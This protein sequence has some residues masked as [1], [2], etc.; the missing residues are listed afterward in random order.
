MKK[1]L[2]EMDKFSLLAAVSGVLL[3]L[4]FPGF[5]LSFLA[6][7]ALVPLL[8]A[9]RGR[10]AG[11]SFRLGF[12]T[13]LISFAGILYW[14][15]PTVIADGEHPL[16]AVFSLLLLSSVLAVFYGL[17][18][19]VLNLLKSKK[20]MPVIIDA[21]IV[22]ALWVSLEWLRGHIFSGLPWAVLGYSQWRNLT[23]IQIS[24]FTAVYGV[25][26]FIIFVNAIIG[27]RFFKRNRPLIDGWQYLVIAL[28]VIVINSMFG[29][30]RIKSVKRKDSGSPARIGILQGNIDQYMKWDREYE[31]LI[32]DSYT[33][34]VAEIKKEKPEVIVWPETAVPGY[35]RLEK[36][37]HGWVKNLA[38]F[39]GAYHIIGSPER[40]EGKFYNS[41]FLVSPGGDILQR[42]DKIHLVPVGEYFPFKAVFKKIFRALDDLGDFNPGRKYERFITPSGIF[43][44]VI[45]Y[46]SIF[47]DLT[48]KIVGMK[49]DYLI[50]ITNDAW[51]LRTAALQ[52]HFS[53]NVFRA[54][55]NR[56]NLVRAANTGISGFI[57]KYGRV[58]KETGIV[59]RVC[60]TAGITG[61]D[62]VTFYTRHGDVFAYSCMVFLLG[63]ILFLKKG[64][65]PD[66]AE[67]DKNEG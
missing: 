24:E 41:A 5:N 34:L 13:G 55:E 64:S 42:Y 7:V 36:K 22:A 21:L 16:I 49:S 1:L 38:R 4:V 2:K 61:R 60:I 27:G 53:M 23:F 33:G 52:Q 46:E 67:G 15:I 30:V 17:F 59:E 45:C 9:L 12:L 35:L 57:N 10:T 32:F 63:T 39:S 26:F 50:N 47:P 37:I 14:I 8:V 11:R 6:W 58:E 65:K 56:I 3:I 19:L 18:C 20:K 43:G 51:Y 48:R 54:V 66:P 44:V 40:E 29:Y 28:A 62:Y 31:E 25:S